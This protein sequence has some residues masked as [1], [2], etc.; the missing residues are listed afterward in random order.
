MRDGPERT[1]RAGSDPQ[2]EKLPEVPGPHPRMADRTPALETSRSAA[3]APDH[4]GRLLPVLRT[5]SL[6]AEARLGTPGGATPVG[7]SA[8]PTQ[9]TPSTVL[10]LSAPPRVVRTAVCAN[11]PRRHLT[12]LTRERDLGSPVRETRTPG[13]AWGDG[14]KG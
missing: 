14:H 3:A 6:Q 10:V 8:A 5:A 13:S 4:A 2:P 11:R 9:S 7:P 12:R 1:I